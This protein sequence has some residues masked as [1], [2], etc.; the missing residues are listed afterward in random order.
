MALGVPMPQIYSLFLTSSSCTLD[1]GCY[2]IC[3]LCFSKKSLLKI[4]T[5][6]AE[7]D[8][9]PAH[10]LQ[11]AQQPHELCSPG[12]DWNLAGQDARSFGAASRVA[13]ALSSQARVPGEARAARPHSPPPAVSSAPQ[14]AGE[15]TLEALSI[16][17]Q[18]HLEESSG[19]QC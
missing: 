4:K 11:G 13:D 15:S 18:F 9:P 14:Q 16:S 8:A 6:S 17:K 3:I 5:R 19:Q 10:G 1:I 2:S 12:S 7:V